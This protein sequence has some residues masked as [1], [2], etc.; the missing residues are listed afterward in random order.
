MKQLLQFRERFASALL[1]TTLLVALLLGAATEA[2]AQSQVS[3]KVTDKDWIGHL[4]IQMRISIFVN[5][6]A[7]RLKVVI[8]SLTMAK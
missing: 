3:G 2:M 1:R 7:V 6:S 5:V 8:A 4:T